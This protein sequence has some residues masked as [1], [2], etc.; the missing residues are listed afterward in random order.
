M[1]AVAAEVLTGEGRAGQVYTLTGLEA[2]TPRQRLAAIAAAL[3]RELRFVELT[4]EQARDRWRQAGYA[5]ELI[6]LL[7]SWQGDPPPSHTRSRP[8]S[9]GCSAA[10]R[11]ASPPG[12]TPTPQPS[13]DPFPSPRPSRS[14]RRDLALPAPEM[15]VSYRTV[16][17]GTAR[18]I[19]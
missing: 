17:A 6:D 9:S 2:L 4:E 10:H 15:P 8:P 19:A 11:A 12:P 14:S 1:G 13:A 18:S 16:R 5:D 3:G 7:A